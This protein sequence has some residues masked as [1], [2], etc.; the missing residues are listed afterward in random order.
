MRA[1]ALPR[2]DVPRSVLRMAFPVAWTVG[3]L[4]ATAIVVTVANASGAAPAAG[5]GACTLLDDDRARL[6][7]FDALFPRGAPPAVTGTAA[8]A[9]TP[10]A[11]PE[12]VFGV[13]DDV[14][15]ARGEILAA[16]AM[17]AMIES[18][19]AR[20]DRL[21][22]GRNRITLANG[23]VW[24]QLEPS[25]RFRPRTGETVTVRQASLG[26][27]LMHASRGS[28]VRARRLR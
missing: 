7:C 6:A 27:Y 25:S 21:E 5:P 9:A 28:A 23:Q 12:S 8:P 20:L 18:T 13:N 1:E 11:T 15:R 24:E 17:P 26:S 16:D 4:L 22:P 14:R 2:R 3:A 10:L 19:V